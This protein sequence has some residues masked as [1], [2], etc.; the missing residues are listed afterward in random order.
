MKK[1]LGIVVLGLLLSGCDENPFKKYYGN[2]VFRVENCMKETSTKLIDENIIKATCVKKIQERVD[3]DI[4]GTAGV[5]KRYSYSD[6]EKLYMKANINNPSNNIVYSEFELTLYHTIDYGENLKENCNQKEHDGCDK[7]GYNIVFDDLWLQ[8][9]SEKI[10]ELDLNEKNF[11]K[12]SKF[13]GKLKLKEIN[14]QAKD[15]MD[16][17]DLIKKGNWSWGITSEKGVI[18]K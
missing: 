12:H 1:L 13:D 7:I 2:T 10:F 4:T 8:P 14:F 18:I 16:G 15:K 5:Y 17:D 11:S 9:K 6:D 3:S